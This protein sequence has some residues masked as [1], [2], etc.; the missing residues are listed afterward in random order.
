[1]VRVVRQPEGARSPL[2]EGVVE[3]VVGPA[4]GGAGW[5]VA[6]RVGDALWVLPED[7]LESSGPHAE[8][9][10]ERI[11]TL[12]LRLVTELTEL[13]GGDVHVEDAVEPMNE[14]GEGRDR[15][16]HPPALDVSAVQVDELATRAQERFDRVFECAGLGSVDRRLD[17]DGADPPVPAHP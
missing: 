3:D 16:A 7:D 2:R 15:S 17:L 10:P 4:E 6:V 14:R 12:Q 8:P 9:P 11:D 1:M 13:T 5:A